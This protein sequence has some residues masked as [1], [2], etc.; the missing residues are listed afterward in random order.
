VLLP[1]REELPEEGAPILPVRGVLSVVF[2]GW[3]GSSRSS[4]SAGIACE[5]L[6]FGEL[7]GFS[8]HHRDQ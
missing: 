3:R 7:K 2:E 6:S 1:P 4:R 5:L 8:Y